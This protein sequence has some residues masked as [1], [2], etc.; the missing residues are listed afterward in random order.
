MTSPS[1]SR[2]HDR[3]RNHAHSNG[4]SSGE[5]THGARDSEAPDIYEQVTARIISQ[6]EAGRLPWVQP[7][8][9]AGEGTGACPA[10]PRNA[11]SG[12]D[13]SGINIL[14][15][16]GELIAKGYP[17]QNWLT[18]R[19]AIQAGGNV[20]KGE[21]GCMLV[22]ADRFIPEAE[23][24]RARESGE[25]ARAVPFL[26][27]FTVFNIAQ[28]E[29]LEGQIIADPVPLPE[30]EIVPVA[31]EVIAASGVDFR[32]GGDKAY[33]MPSLDVVQV[34]PQPAFFEQINY[35]RTCLHELTHATG[36]GSR[37]ARDLTNGFG[38]PGYAREE[39]IAEMGSAFLC[40]SLGIVPTVR[41]SDYIGAWLAVL[42]EDNRA[43]F[44]AARAAS[45]AADWLLERHRAAQQGRVDRSPM[46]RRKPPTPCRGGRHDPPFR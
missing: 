7:W 11:L 1:S 28:C 27:R 25:E 30:R 14:L 33:Y 9:K 41:H 2:A 22:Y 36:H 6:L 35:Y 3:R 46:I 32:V 40:A 23:K 4:K 37:L 31:E 13:Y 5:R 38:T 45:L 34:P 44:R 16:W 15:L 20:R 43:I 21:H 24:A 12:R 26:K 10:L 18:F 19:Q 29:G 42:R 8:V 17:S 39:L